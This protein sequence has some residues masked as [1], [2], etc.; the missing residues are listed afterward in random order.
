VTKVYR[1]SE[2]RA[3]RETTRTARSGQTQT[4]VTIFDPVAGFEARLNPEKLTA[5]KHTLPPQNG[6]APTAPKPPSGEN[7]PQVATAD[8]G[9][10]TIEGLAVTGK[11]VTT[12]I[13]AGEMGNSEAIQTVR[14][15]WTST[16]LKVPVMITST[17]PRFGTSTTQLSGVSQAE[18]DA[19]LFQIPSNYT[20]STRAGH[21]GPP[22]PGGGQ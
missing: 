21:R 15:V 17:N 5:E 14:V 7:A 16:V 19:T 12:T 20:V 8:L 4:F 11:Q 18:P 10:K 3:R 22:P 9:S 13:P 6:T 1:D 2:G